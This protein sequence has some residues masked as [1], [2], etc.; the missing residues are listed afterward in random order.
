MADV[1]ISSLPIGTPSSNG[2]IPFSQG[3][4]TY[5]ARPS[6]IVA[7]NLGGILAVTYG[8][9]TTEYSYSPQ[10]TQLYTTSFTVNLRKSNSL[11]ILETNTYA[12]SLAQNGES[13]Q[14][15]FLLA[16]LGQRLVI[17]LG[18]GNYNPI[19]GYDDY[20]FGYNLVQPSP[21][22]NIAW[23]GCVVRKILLTPGV[24]SISFRNHLTDGSITTSSITQKRFTWTAYEVAQ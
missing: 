17:D 7:G 3:S 1:T 8:T 2:L 15:G 12:Y 6:A 4:T 11:L 14:H 9:D 10:Y 16:G 24:N 22:V 21:S 23:S 18:G 19:T 20:E 13:G 5:S